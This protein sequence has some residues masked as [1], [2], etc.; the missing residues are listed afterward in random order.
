MHHPEHHMRSS[1]E[2]HREAHGPFFAF[3]RWIPH[4]S[5]EKLGVMFAVVF[6]CV[7]VLS[8]S[9]GTALGSMWATNGGAAIMPNNHLILTDGHPEQARSAFYG[10]PVAVDAFEATFIY[11]DVGA[12]GADGAA[13]V[14]QNDARKSAALGGPGE[15]LGYSG[16]SKITNSVALAFNIYSSPGMALKT[17]GEVGAYM[18][19]APVNLSSGNPIEITVLYQNSLM[20]VTLRDRVTG[21]SFTNS[22]S[23][24]LPTVVGGHTA[25][26]GFTG[27]CGGKASYQ[28]ISAFT[29]GLL[30]SRPEVRMNVQPLSL[31][32]PAGLGFTLPAAVTGTEPLL[33]QWQHNGTNL[34]DNVGTSGTHANALINTTP[35]SGDAGNYQLIVSNSYGVA[36]SSV[37]VV[38]VAAPGLKD[39]PPVTLRGQRVMVAAEVKD[40][41]LQERYSGLSGGKWIEVAQTAQQEAMGSVSI[42]TAG[43]TLMTGSVRNVQISDDGALVEELAIGDHRVVRKITVVDGGPWIRVVTRFEP[44][45]SVAFRQFCDRFKFSHSPDWTFS[46]SVGGFVPD[47]IYKAPLILVQSKQVSFGIV[48]DLTTLSRD[49][50]QLCNHALDL[51]VPDGPTLG[52]GFMPA[53]RT[54]HSVYSPDLNRVWTNGSAIEN[55]YFMMVN[56]SSAPTEA[57]RD[58]VRFH[59][60]QFGRDAQAH[61]ASQQVGTDSRYKSLALWD[62]WRETTWKQ[63][64]TEQWLTVNLPDGSVGGGVRTRRWGPGPSVYLS[65]WF[66]TLRTSFGMALYAKRSNNAE[67]LR[68]A[69][70]TVELALKAPGPNGAFKCIAVPTEQGQNLWAAGDGS[71][72][73]TKDG[74][75]GYDMCWTGYWLLRWRAAGLPES[76]GILPRCRKLAEFMMARQNS[77]GMLPTRFAEDGSVEEALSRTVKAETGP[78]VLFLL[79]LYH[80][81]SNTNYLESAR[82][83]LAFLEREVVSTRQWYDFETFY[84]CSPRRADFDERTQQWPVNN[85]ALTQTAEAFLLAYK[86][87]GEQHYLATGEA[88]LD[89]L[90]LYQQ[91]WTNPRLDGLTCDTMLLGGFTTQNS[92]AE[93]SDARQSQCGNILLDYYRITRKVEYLE[94]GVAA[95]RAQFPVSPSENWAHEG[96]GGKAGIS[97]FH[98]GTGSGLAGIE[99]EEDDLRDAVVDVAAQRAIG[100]NGLDLS[101]CKVGNGQIQFELSS[102]FAWKRQP[103]VVFRQTS[104]A[105]SYRIIVNGVNAGVWLGADLEKGIPLPAP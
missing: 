99:M 79:E 7:A 22:Y 8:G 5:D 34:N 97:S 70:Q 94:R 24:D 6:L 103:V 89:Y 21:G 11:Q 52:I 61:A 82:K 73:S 25:Y 53:G 101:D 46:P 57:Y 91:C 26:V 71:M 47:A 45:R 83:G 42:V 55:A 62:D 104:P 93:W 64:S 13:F 105:Q 28:T 27:G 50:L 23:V 2:I 49:T 72:N 19:T 37:V 81:D 56:A 100:V 17:G 69:G 12:N 96:Y 30:R 48:P 1:L 59:W 68:L 51:Q 15:W 18:G 85:L 84:S 60:H 74:F 66:N 80:Q 67:L 76:E 40:G 58:A 90:L 33:Y 14:L 98:W 31:M 78:A 35:R 39:L 9:A 75:L 20:V 95:L 87:T 29:F 77:D 44:S 4:R 10:F 36:T 88:V 38:M 86:V 102:P 63:E 3:T 41:R 92:D 54:S 16:A 32:R 43:N 65:A